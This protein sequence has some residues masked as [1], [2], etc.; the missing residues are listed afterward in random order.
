MATVSLC[1]AIT[2]NPSKHQSSTTLSI[3]QLQRTNLSFV[4]SN[5]LSSLNLTSPKRD[6]PTLSF[7]AKSTEAESVETVCEAQVEESTETENDQVVEAEEPKREEVF[8]VV[9]VE[10]VALSG[11][12]Y[13]YL[14]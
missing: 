4:L 13:N 9:M 1:S 10:F 12:F 8:A 5:A 3:S 14:S 11:C 2:R 6:E 7:V